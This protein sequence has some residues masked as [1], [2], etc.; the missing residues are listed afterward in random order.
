MKVAQCPCRREKE[1]SQFNDP[2]TRDLTYVGWART[3]VI[4]LSCHRFPNLAMT[5]RHHTHVC[6]CA[7]TH[8]HTHT[9]LWSGAHKTKMTSHTVCLSFLNIANS[10]LIFLRGILWSHVNFIQTTFLRKENLVSCTRIGG[11]A[12]KTYLHQLPISYIAVCV[13]ESKPSNSPHPPLPPYL[14][15]TSVSLFLLCKWIHLYHFS[16]FHIYALICNICLPHSVWQSLDPSENI[17]YST[18]DST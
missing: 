9:C 13:C 5:Q 17:L 4:L 16:R 18:G 14:F 11:R 8:T 15:S 7:H 1:G 6:V 2:E 3:Y 10:G 12:V